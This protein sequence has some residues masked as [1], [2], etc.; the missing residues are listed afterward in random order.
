MVV[1][2][3]NSSYTGGR[4]QEGHGSRTAQKNLPRSPSQQISQV[5]WYISVTPTLKESWGK[6]CSLR[7]ASGKNR[8]TLSKKRTAVKR[9]GEHGS[10]DREPT[11]Q[12]QGAEFKPQYHQKLR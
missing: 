2:A 7:L 4:N 11:C 3:F 1:P 9:A 8:V 5:Q 10:R 12:V 6:D